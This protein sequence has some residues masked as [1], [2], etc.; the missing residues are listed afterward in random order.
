MN[1]QTP[2][3]RNTDPESSHIAATAVTKKGVRK[4]RQQALTKLLIKEF[5][6][7]KTSAELARIVDPEHFPDDYGLRRSEVAR[8]L[9]D[10]KHITARKGKTRKCTELGTTA[11]EWWPLKLEKEISGGAAA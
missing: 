1:I 7:G 6:W 4:L 8:R 2:A 5:A 9:S 3:A 10:I 11:A